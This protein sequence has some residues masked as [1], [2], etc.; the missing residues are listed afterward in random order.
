ME[1]T[2]AAIY[3]HCGV[4]PISLTVSSAGEIGGTVRLPDTMTCASANATASGCV[5]SQGI[6]LELRGP[7]ISIRGTLTKG[8]QALDAP[9]AGGFEGAYSG[10]LSSSVPGGQSGFRPLS[11]DLRVSQGRLTGQFVRPTCGT[12]PISLPVDA[13]GAVSGRVRIYEANGCAMNE[14]QVSGR[15]TA[16][17]VTLDIRGLSM[18]VRGSLS[19]SAD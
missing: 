18:S 1:V 7:G 12:T 14:A 11:A 8:G 3:Q 16:E 15:V 5:T 4:V 9:A 6:L 17:A 2:G 19:R 10:A 13:A